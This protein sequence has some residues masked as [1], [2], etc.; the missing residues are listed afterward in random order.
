MDYYS[1]ILEALEEVEESRA[2]V[3]IDRKGKFFT[4]SVVSDDALEKLKTL[5]E[6]A[7]GV[8]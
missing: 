4:L 7:G 8:V 1:K 3:L 6:E 5:I 2:T